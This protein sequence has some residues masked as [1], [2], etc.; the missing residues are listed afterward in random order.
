MYQEIDPNELINKTNINLIDIRDYYIYSSGTIKGARNIPYNFL[1]TNP[2]DYL[3][4]NEVY[5]I[6]CSQG[7][8]SRK[9]CRYLASK[10]YKVVNII[11]GYKAYRDSII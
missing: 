2:E 11:G 6:F 5:Y 4:K 3:N 10:G 1:F 8:T 7:I 9:L